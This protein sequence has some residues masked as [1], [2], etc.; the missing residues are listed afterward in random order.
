MK[1]SVKELQGLP[2]K[3]SFPSHYGC[4]G[5]PLLLFWTISARLSFGNKKLRTRKEINEQE[6]NNPITS[7][8]FLFLDTELQEAQKLTTNRTNT[9]LPPHLKCFIS[10][11]LNQGVISL[12]E[13]CQWLGC[14]LFCFAAITISQVFIIFSRDHVVAPTMVVIPHYLS[15][16]GLKA[17]CAILCNFLLS[18]F[19]FRTLYFIA[20][21]LCV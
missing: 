6:Q 20:F 15:S 18:D 7:K 10:Q 19:S 16:P 8:A 21:S 3:S 14:S 9:K 5:N 2:C 1:R 4:E 13:E 12:Y 17:F 11:F